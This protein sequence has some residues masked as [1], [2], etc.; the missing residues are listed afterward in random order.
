MKRKI[1]LIVLAVM[2]AVVCFG[3]LAACSKGLD[4]YAVTTLLREVENAANGAKGKTSY[5]LPTTVSFDDVD[6][7][8][9]SC[10][11]QWTADSGVVVT[12]GDGAV[13]VTVP[14]GVTSYILTGTLVDAKGN[15]YKSEKNPVRLS[16]SVSGGTI[17]PNPN[18]S[19]DKGTQGNPYT[20]AEALTIING[21]A[22][23]GFSTSAVYVQGIV[24]GTVQTSSQT[25][26]TYNFDL[27]DAA[28]NAD[29]L[30]IW[31]ALYADGTPAAG[32]TAVIYGYLQKYTNN[33]GSKAE[34]NTNGGVTLAISSLTKGGVTP[35]PNPDG[36][37]TQSNP[38]TVAEALAV[39]DGLAQSAYSATA[40]YTTGIV[41]NYEVGDKGQ[42][43][44]NI[45]DTAGSSST[46][47]VYWADLGSGVT[48]FKDG[49]TVIV[50]GYLM[51]FW[52]N[53]TSTKTPEVAANNNVTPT[54]VSVNGSSIQTPTPTPTPTPDPT[55]APTPD[56]TLLATIGLESVAP[57]SSSDEQ[58]V[59]TENGITVTNDKAGS[60]NAPRTNADKSARFY[61]SSTITVEY[62]SAF[63]T[64]VITLDDYVDPNNSKT[65]MAGFNDMTVDG[66]TITVSGN[67][68]TIVLS[69]A[70][71]SFTSAQLASQTRIKSIQIYG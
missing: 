41:S 13:T 21:L 45:A 36:K 2:L 43:R 8:T 23:N 47:C 27:V 38:Y 5:T 7:K 64:I 61:Q 60:N 1:S 53:K 48:S 55:P 58:K 35:N 29:K 56:G 30:I 10:A 68:V 70:G 11:V 6:L 62:T 20:V 69:S 40:V 63:T 25:A 33:S 3:A 24:S 50:Y 28:G 17:D 14:S 22:D 67:I 42:Y 71:T 65:Y 52:N 59:Y 39:I 66:A 34:M 32:D 37:G 16:I 9:I 31:W 18:P 19:G 12:E 15:A 51:H 57:S 49:D 26:N 46:I 54:V 4:D 44:F